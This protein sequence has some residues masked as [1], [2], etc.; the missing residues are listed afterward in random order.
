MR[1][2]GESDVDF[3]LNWFS[4]SGEILN[5]CGTKYKVIRDLEI[6]QIKGCGHAEEG[7]SAARVSELSL[8]E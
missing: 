3:V 1:S 2:L 4:L 5:N 6:A 7:V 8:E